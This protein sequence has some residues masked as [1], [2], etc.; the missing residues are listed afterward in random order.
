M[1][2][3]CSSTTLKTFTGTVSHTEY[4]SAYALQLPSTC[5]PVPYVRD[6]PSRFKVLAKLLNSGNLNLPLQRG[7]VTFEPPFNFALSNLRLG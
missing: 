4:Y 1:D 5:Y 3:D 2:C 7:G 6:G